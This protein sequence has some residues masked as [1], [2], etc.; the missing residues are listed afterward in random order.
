MRQTRFR[1][2]A[3]IYG[4]SLDRWPTAERSDARVHRTSQPESQTL[5]DEAARLDRC[6]DLTAETVDDGTV[7]HV[8]AG[9][10][11]QVDR[12]EVARADVVAVRAPFFRTGQAWGGA[13]VFAAL[14][15][16]GFLVGQT[17]LLPYHAQPTDDMTRLVLPK[18][19]LMA[20]ER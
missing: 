5:L 1:R 19:F 7:D 8:L 6:L 16:A 2:L 11:R 4:G 12:Q 10:M 3:D 17:G 15:V 18:I 20:S 13:G 9:L 14:L